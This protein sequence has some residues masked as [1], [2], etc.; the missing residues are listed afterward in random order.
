MIVTRTTS[1]PEL[2]VDGETRFI[3][4]PRDL[5]ALGVKM[6]LLVGNPDL[7]RRLGRQARE[8]VRRRFT[9]DKTAEL[10]LGFYRRLLT[11]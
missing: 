10:A 6:T 7:S 3:V 1:L 9:W 8:H 4:P 2:V 5:G 11:A